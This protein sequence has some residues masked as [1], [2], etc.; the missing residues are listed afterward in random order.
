MELELG[1]GSRTDVM[2]CLVSCTVTMATLLKHA[3]VFG[4]Q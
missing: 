2:E 1:L 3:S 4:S